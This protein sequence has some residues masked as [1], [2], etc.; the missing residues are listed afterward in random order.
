MD[1]AGTLWDR[2]DLL[3]MQLREKQRDG[4]PWRKETGW[5]RNSNEE[6]N[7]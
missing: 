2:M 5:T 7:A 4:S 1:K 3:G 6:G